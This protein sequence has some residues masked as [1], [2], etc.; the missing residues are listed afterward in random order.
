MADRERQ[1]HH[2]QCKEEQ[3]VDSKGSAVSPRLPGK[4][5]LWGQSPVIAMLLVFIRSSCASSCGNSF[6]KGA[7]TGELVAHPS[8]LALGRRLSG[9]LEEGEPAT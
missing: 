7:E 4:P 5:S 1:R 8:V 3:R 2:C 9:Q 6:F